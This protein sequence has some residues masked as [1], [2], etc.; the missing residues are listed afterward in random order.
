MLKI[1][2]KKFGRDFK[3]SKILDDASLTNDPDIFTDIWESKNKYMRK[4]VQDNKFL[5]TGNNCLKNNVHLYK[6][7]YV[8]VVGFAPIAFNAADKFSQWMEEKNPR[9]IV[10]G[11]SNPETFSKLIRLLKNF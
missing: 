9:S 8:D 7:T 5:A 3:K 6:S 11:T 10:L 2:S 1:I 4:L